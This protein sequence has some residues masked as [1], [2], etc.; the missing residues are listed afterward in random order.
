MKSPIRYLS[1]PFTL[2]AG[3][4]ELV[5]QFSIRSVEERTRGSALG[6]VWTLLVP[7]LLMCLYTF[8][9]GILFQGSFHPE[10]RE[11][12]LV[13]GIGIYIGLAILGLVN[14]TMGQAPTS[15]L[16]Q[17]NLVKKVVFPLE[18]LPLTNVAFPAIQMI[19]GLVISGIALFVIG[20][21]P[22]VAWFWIPI[23]V[24]P[25]ALFAV[26]LSWTLAS[27]SVYFRDIEQVT[28]IFTQ[29]LFWASGIFFAAHTVQAYPVAWA[30]LKWNPVLL[31]IDEVRSVMIWGLPISELRIVYL[32]ALGISTFYIGFHICRKL[33]R[34]FAD[35]L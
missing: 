8:V 2:V 30:I 1:G 24:L 14:E 20:H 33:K 26:G 3:H 17:A 23:L 7:F 32:Y 18:V 27:I 5:R 22:T 11:N 25:L 10:E 34:G 21:P 4:F 29:V 9:F 19:S 6:V 31:V 13:F 12:P 35:V 28:R 15:I 16:G